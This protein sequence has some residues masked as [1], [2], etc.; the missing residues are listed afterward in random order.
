MKM[1][2]YYSAYADKEFGHCIYL[3]PEGIEIK[4]T[5]V[6]SQDKPAGKWNDFVY[7]GEVTECIKPNGIA[8]DVSP[9]TLLQKAQAMAAQQKS[10]QSQFSSTGQCF[11][12]TC[13]TKR[14]SN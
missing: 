1:Y 6:T 10:C 8:W 11:C 9:D 4:V 2:G 7:L 14:N 3:T 13:P 12:Y 5:E